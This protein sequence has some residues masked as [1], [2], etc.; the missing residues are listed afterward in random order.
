MV[1]SNHMLEI[2]RSFTPRHTTINGT[3]N[4]LCAAVSNTVVPIDA[5]FNLLK[6]FRDKYDHKN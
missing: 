4:Y 3:N 2:G 6:V 5:S 1:N